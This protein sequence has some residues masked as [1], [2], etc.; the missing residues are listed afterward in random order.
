MGW[1]GGFTRTRHTSIQS[2]KVAALGGRT[3][4]LDTKN[5]SM[6]MRAGE[7]R[8]TKMIKYCDTTPSPSHTAHPHHSTQHTLTIPHSTPSSSQSTHP[9]LTIPVPLPS[10]TA[11]PHHSSHHTLTIPVPS[12]SHTAHPHHSSHHTL[13]IPVHTAHPHHSSHHT[14]T[15]PVHTAHPHHS[16]L[17][18][19]GTPA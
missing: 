2:V 6:F 3:C 14:L 8:G 19:S 5:F 11:H 18:S 15:I 17:P 7:E 13:T 10:H 1:G 16:T 12:P 4:S 9:T